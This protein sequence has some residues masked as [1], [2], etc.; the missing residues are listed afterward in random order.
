VIEKLYPDSSST[1]YTY[2]NTTSRLK[3]LTDAKGQITHYDYNVDD[4]LSRVTYLNAIVPTHWVSFGYDTKYTRVTSMTDG[5]GT[6]TFSYLAVSNP[7]THL[8]RQ[9][10][11]KLS[12]VSS[13]FT[14]STVAY[15]YD[16]LGRI[17][18]RA[19]DG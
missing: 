17:T 4:T 16:E 15:K 6:T 18:N 3:N 8:P 7:I 1:S 14:G 9:G 10:G 13:S 5:T 19:V 11:G 2:E 12:A